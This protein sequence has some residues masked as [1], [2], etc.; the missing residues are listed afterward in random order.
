MLGQFVSSRASAPGLVLLH[1]PPYST[2]LPGLGKTSSLPSTV[3]Q[4]P[5][6]KMFAS[7]MLG[8]V[9]GAVVGESKFTAMQFWYISRLPTLL[10]QLHERNMFFP[11]GALEGMVNV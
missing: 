9:I 5:L 7:N 11:E 1:I 8:N 6:P 10:N 2:E 3:L 4:V